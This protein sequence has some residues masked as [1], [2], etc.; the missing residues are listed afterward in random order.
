VTLPARRLPKDPQALEEL[1]RD[2]QVRRAPALAPR[3]P[4]AIP[5]GFP[6]LDTALGGGLVRGQLHEI[7]G[8]PGAGGTALVRAALASATCAGE[9]CALIDPGDAFDPAPCGIDLQRLLWVRPHDPVQALRAAE[10]A[11]EARFA[12]V[13]LDLGDVSV[14]APP[15]QPCGVIQV[16][17]FEKKPPSPGASP[18]MRLA[19]RAEKHGGVLLVLARAAQ[20]GT[21]AA[22]TIELERDRAQWEG[23]KGAAGRF[24]RG[25]HAIG[26]VAR[27]KRMPPSAPLPLHLSLEPK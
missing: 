4:P 9:N 17:R 2:G 19:R 20:A 13:A 11:L 18:W 5:T 14:L 1:L 24:L 15:R 10:L 27:H 16:V 23:Q 21:F 22:A 3:S 25:A 8:P 7:V 12:L 6:P 26:A